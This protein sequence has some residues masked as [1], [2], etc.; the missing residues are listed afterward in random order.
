MQRE[1][2]KLVPAPSSVYAL[3]KVEDDS[4]YDL[5][6]MTEKCKSFLEKNCVRGDI[7]NFSDTLDQEYRNDKRFAYD[8]EKI[9]SLFF[10]YIDYGTVPLEFLAF[11]EFPPAYFSDSVAHNSVCWVL[12][13]DRVR[14]E[15]LTNVEP[16]PEDGNKWKSWATIEGKKRQFRL[17]CH[18]PTYSL[19]NRKFTHHGVD[20]LICSGVDDEGLFEGEEEGDIAYVIDV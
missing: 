3:P 16:Y 19:S 17:Y 1:K 4:E 2:S 15:I 8:G 13:T 20:Y 10:D 12:L 9:I 7:L 14:E 6:D 18:N 11:T 5:E